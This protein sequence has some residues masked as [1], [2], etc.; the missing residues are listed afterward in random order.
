M[1]GRNFG[2]WTADRVDIIR[3]G[4][5]SDGARYTTLAGAALGP[6]HE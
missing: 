5:A 1:A 2:E 6:S 3:S 4:L